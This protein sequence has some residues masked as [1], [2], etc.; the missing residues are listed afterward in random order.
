MYSPS[1]THTPSVLR[2]YCKAANWK[3]E[4]FLSTESQR[5]LLQHKCS[6]LSAKQGATLLYNLYFPSIC[7]RVPF[8][9]PV[10]LQSPD[11]AWPAL[12]H[13]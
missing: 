2:E 6:N 7:H 8:P 12:A 5:A 9:P 13:L 4:C 11:G 10:L 1:P 3:A